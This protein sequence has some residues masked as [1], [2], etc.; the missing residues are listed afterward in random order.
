MHI[1][2]KVETYQKETG[3][4]VKVVTAAAN[5]YEQ[6]LKSEIAKSS[7]LSHYATAKT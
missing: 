4:K 2:E 7:A 1:L 6:T 3:I 5:T